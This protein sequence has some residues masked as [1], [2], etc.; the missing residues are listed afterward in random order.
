MPYHFPPRKI[1][2]V[3]HI[4]L[5]GSVVS[6]SILNIFIFYHK[7][8]LFFFQIQKKL[9]QFS[10]CQYFSIHFPI[11]ECLPFSLHAQ[12]SVSSASFGAW[13]NEL[14]FLSIIQDFFSSSIPSVNHLTSCIWG[15]RGRTWPTDVSSEGTGD[16]S[17]AASGRLHPVLGLA[18][19]GIE[20]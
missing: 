12:R 14:P 11:K 20:P 9:F 19:F 18:S 8:Q 13:R 10:K 1:Q 15:R 4:T 3:F 6:G 16:S 5:M 2:I 17:A 7:Q